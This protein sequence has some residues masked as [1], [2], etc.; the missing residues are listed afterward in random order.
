MALRVAD[1]YFEFTGIETVTSPTE[2]P[3]TLAQVKEYMRVTASDQDSLITIFIESAAII[4][5]NYLGAALI[6]KQFKMVL[7][8]VPNKRGDTIDRYWTTSTEAEVIRLRR[9]PLVTVDSITVDGTSYT[10][11]DY[12]IVDGSQKRPRL[13]PKDNATLPVV[14]ANGAGIE[15]TFTAGYGET[16]DDI[17]ANI[18]TAIMMLSAYLYEHRGECSDIE[19]FNNSGAMGI[20]KQLRPPRL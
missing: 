16:T 20:V 12:F 1:K 6:N 5:E 19:A 3:V 11:N 15:I 7:D 4:I 13:I 10:V 17:P 9:W 2:L 8:D 14:D 18:K